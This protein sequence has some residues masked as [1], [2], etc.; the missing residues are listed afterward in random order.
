[1]TITV[2]SMNVRGLN[3]LYKMHGH[4]EGSPDLKSEVLFLQEMHF[5]STKLP[6]FRFQHF[7]HLFMANAPK[8]KCGVLI[9]IK[10]S[11]AFKHIQEIVDPQ[12]RYVILICERNHT[13]YTLVNLY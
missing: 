9:A 12:G 11:I 3:S 1:M 13:K 2:L 10:D 6:H 5:A 8:K 7:P 4:H